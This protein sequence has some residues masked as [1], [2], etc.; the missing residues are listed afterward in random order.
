MNRSKLLKVSLYS[1]IISAVIFVINYFFYHFVTDDGI[2]TTWHPEPGK[3]F[4]SD[5]IGQLGVLMMFLSITTLLF[6]LI[7][8]K[9]ED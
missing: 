1:I 2:T 5:L 6:A 4:V 9:K 3:P 8:Y 7:F